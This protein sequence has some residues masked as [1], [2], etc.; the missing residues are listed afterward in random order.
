[1]KKLSFN[2]KEEVIEVLDIE[3]NTLTS[4]QFTDEE[5]LI[6]HNTLNFNVQFS[7]N[8]NLIHMMKSL[9]EQIGNRALL[10]LAIQGLQNLVIK[11]SVYGQKN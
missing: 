10:L 8:I 2:F 11:A 3:D 4:L 6:L 1:M 9:H 7:R 5:K